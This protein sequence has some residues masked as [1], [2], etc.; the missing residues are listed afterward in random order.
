MNKKMIFL[1]GWLVLFPLSLSADQV[2]FTNGDRLTG[3]VLRSDSET[4][5]FLSDVAGEIRVP[6]VAVGELTARQPMVL[7]LRDG[8]MVAGTVR[9]ANGGIE[10]VTE[11]SS[12][13]MAPL[14]QIESLRTEEEQQE[15]HRERERIRNPRW[16]EL[17]EGALDAG[18]STSRGNSDTLTV[19][20]GLNAART[21]LNDRLST[22][23]TLLFS[24]NSTTGAPLRTANTVQG[25]FRY[26]RN[27]RRRF[28]SFGFTDL[29][30][31]E[32]K[33]L[34]LRT[35]VGGGLGWYAK[36]AE[37]VRL[38]LFSGGS[39]NQ[40]NFSSGVTRRS[41]EGLAGQELSYRLSSRVKFT[42]RG[43][44]YANLSDP[45]E[46]RLTLDGSLVTRI[47]GRFGWHVTVSDRFLSNP[48]LGTRK[49]D[50]LLTTGVRLTFGEESSARFQARLP[51]VVKGGQD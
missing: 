44:A 1:F 7:T 23:L 12:R 27:I 2:V 30:F 14:S 31:D 48:I 24:E 15:F 28:F 42:E 21:T 8:S 41:A 33:D 47:S 29:E 11:D 39:F 46:Y 6:W 9:F 34:D 36:Q 10:I 43:I 49:N 32:L 19:S 17:W 4:L 37:R 3:T 22:Y 13:R 45:G 18:L 51:D 50:L 5:S 38:A 26:D 25:G 16:N 20:S 40:E 35:V